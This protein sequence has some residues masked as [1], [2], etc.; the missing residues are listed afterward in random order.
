MKRLLLLIVTVTLTGCARPGDHPV[1]PNCV[2]SEDDNRSLDLRQLSDRRHLRF[3]AVTAEDMA[4]RWADQHFSLR[5]E[6]D[7]QCAQCME[8]LFEGVAKHHSI[9]V[10]VVRQYSQER[11]AVADAVVIL[12]FAF[13]YVLAAYILTGRILRQF[14]PGESGFWI[15]T[16]A[17]AVGVSLVGVLVG[18]LWSIVFETFRL[19]SVHLSYRMNRIPFRQHWAVLFVCCFVVFGLVAVM[20]SRV[21]LQ[22]Q[23]SALP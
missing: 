16:L 12:S 4:I 15:M 11:D 3:D 22:T 21:K 19:N 10:A 23:C 7:R 6:Y 13:L 8:T 5:P 14:P 17:M 2:W 1:S 18:S 9:D 20:R